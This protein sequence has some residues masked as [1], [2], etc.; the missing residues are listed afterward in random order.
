MGV[1]AVVVRRGVVVVVVVVGVRRGLVLLLVGQP[2]RAAAL[3]SLGSSSSAAAA[4]WRGVAAWTGAYPPWTLP[5][6]CTAASRT[7]SK[8]VRGWGRARRGRHWG[9]ESAA[10]CLRPWR[11]AYKLGLSWGRHHLRLLFQQ[12]LAVSGGMWTQQALRAMT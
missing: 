6:A 4:V 1:M 9:M 10:A 12:K 11:E 7:A 3:R 8:R 2:G 5:S